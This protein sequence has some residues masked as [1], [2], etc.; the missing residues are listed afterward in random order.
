[1]VSGKVNN[2]PIAHVLIDSRKLLFTEDALFIAIN[3]VRNN[4]HAFLADA[5]NAGVRNFVVEAGNYELAILKELKDSVVLE[6]TSGLYALQ[7]I[8]S[9]HRSA[10]NLQTLAVTGSNGKTVVKEWLAHLL[11]DQLAVVRSPRSYN[12]QTGVPLSVLQIQPQHQLGIFEAGI[13][14][15][16]EMQALEKII[17]PQQGIFTLL[18]DAHD[19]GFGSRQQKLEEKAKLF[20]NCSMVVY[21]AE[22]NEVKGYFEKEK[23]NKK[24]GGKKF[25][26]W[27][28]YPA[29]ADLQIH[30]SVG[31][32]YTELSIDNIQMRIPFTDEASVWNA[33][34]CLSW[35]HFSRLL[36]HS[37]AERFS[38]LP[39]LDM[40]L[41]LREGQQNCHIINDSYSADLGS[42][43]IAL[44]FMQQQAKGK[45]TVVIL[46][47]FLE[48][49]KGEDELYHSIARELTAHGIHR[50][51]GIGEAMCRNQ[52]CFETL[53][54][55]FFNNVEAFFAHTTLNKFHDEVILLKGARAFAFERIS[56]WLERKVHQT[57]FE[58]NLNALVHNLNTYRACLKPGVKVMAMVKAFSYGAGS[59][60]IARVLAFNRVDYLTVAY[61]DEGVALRKSGITLPIMVMNPEAASFETILQYHLEPEVYHFEVLH[62]LLQQVNGAE[63]GIHL[64]LDSGMKRLGFDA[65]EVDKLLALLQANPNLK[66]RSVFSHLAASE[67]PAHDAFTLQQMEV[68]NQQSRRITD[69]LP[70]PV[71][72]HVL[73]SGGIARFPDAQHDMVRLGIGLY[74]VDPTER[75]L[76][77]LPIGALKTVVSQIREID[78]SE[79]IG[80]GRKGKLAQGGRIAIVA[81]GYADGLDRRL[82]NG[83]GAME[84]N[85][86]L[87]PVV[88]NICMDMT[89]LDVTNIPC[90]VGDRVTVFGSKPTLAEVA[91]QMQTIPYEVLT[92]IS[93]RV[94]R[95]YFYE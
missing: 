10:H 87:A 28:R 29:V 67:D 73:N 61:A 75:Q 47:D 79:S 18:G 56:K 51:M 12:S 62:S 65:S 15:P 16:G 17:Q 45:N 55:Q 53:D 90:K 44:E 71:L 9:L 31:A 92:G 32:D 86:M 11:K 13:S 57:V 84:V 82:S 91:A 14:E 20:A 63:V 22:Q 64:E 66:V 41:Q 94:K 25:F 2:S 77:L 83:V 85:G 26:S 46:S 70:Y 76:S 95:V 4:S 27:A 60:E 21:G 43:R 48:S 7:T 69:A 37:V 52:K 74:G 36:N 6:T 58:V 39:A 42:L 38:D 59:D 3:G 68:F 72:R 54:A 35:L 34:T 24:E 8:A 93:Q 88:G 80:Y 19:E 33:C 23:E 78:A 5:W 40:R 30:A 49:G 50:F 1:M 89:M 81:I